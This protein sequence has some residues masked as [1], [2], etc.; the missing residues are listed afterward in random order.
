[1]REVRNQYVIKLTLS[2]VRFEDRG[3]GMGVKFRRRAVSDVVVGPY[4][5]SSAP[6]I[7]K[8]R[9]RKPTTVKFVPQSIDMA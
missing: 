3:Y 4:I 6:P 9:M 7:I 1:M 8:L 2:E 5:L